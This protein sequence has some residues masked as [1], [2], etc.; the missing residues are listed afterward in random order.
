[1]N[2]AGFYEESISNGDGVRA[3]IFVS[4]CPHKCKGC[5]NEEAQDFDFRRTL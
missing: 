5:H 3:V 4:G 2:L 1:M